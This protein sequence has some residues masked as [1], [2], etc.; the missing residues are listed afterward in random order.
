MNRQGST[1]EVLIDDTSGSWAALYDDNGRW[2][3]RQDGP[4]NLW[5][6]IEERLSQWHAAGA[7]ALDEFTVTITPDRQ[8]LRW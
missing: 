6:S 7:P 5:D 2:I 1:E 3:V 4:D 8:S